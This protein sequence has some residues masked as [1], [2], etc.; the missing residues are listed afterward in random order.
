MT[1][2]EARPLLPPGERDVPIDTG[3]ITKRNSNKDHR[4]FTNP[5]NSRRSSR[6]NGRTQSNAIR[7]GQGRSLWRR[8]N[9]ERTTLPP[10]GK[11]AQ[12]RAYAPG[13]RSPVAALHASCSE[14]SLMKTV[15][16]A[17]IN[18]GG[19]LI[20]AIHTTTGPLSIPLPHHRIHFSLS[21]SL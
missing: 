1:R 9:Q 15:L 5:T 3:S 14:M 11:R 13:H 12:G 18:H 21:L 10:T 17:I 6:N 8:H 19:S 16:Y 20:V 7:V 2:R 4:Q